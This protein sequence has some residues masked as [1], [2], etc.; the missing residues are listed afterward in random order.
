MRVVFDTNVL[1]SASLWD[2]SVAHKLLINLIEKD[3]ELFTS[4]EIL[5][6]YEG[7][8]IRDFKYS[9]EEVKKRGKDSYMISVRQKA[10]RNQANKRVCEVL[11]LIFGISAENVRIINGHQSPSKLM[12][13]NL[14][15]N[16]V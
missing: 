2:N 13:V 11:A 7:A 1:I 12:S 8:V 4:F 14:P 6:E 10:E 15:E 5:R 9:K 16:R 3:V